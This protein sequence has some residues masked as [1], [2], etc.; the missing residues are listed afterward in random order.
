MRPCS[1]VAAS[2]PEGPDRW[3]RFLG[4]PH[5]GTT[6]RGRAHSP[7]NPK[8]E[9]QRSLCTHTYKRVRSGAPRTER[10]RSTHMEAGLPA[11][12]QSGLRK[13]K[14]SF[15]PSDSSFCFKFKVK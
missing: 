15:L 7:A 9:M 5:G 1:W 10:L 6:A 3:T 12:S 4:V 13:M 14:M 11:T 2:L 8:A